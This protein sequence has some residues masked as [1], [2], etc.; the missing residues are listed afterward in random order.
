MKEFKKYDQNYTIFLLRANVL[1]DDNFDR[2]KLDIFPRT[3][4]G[5]IDYALHRKSIV[6][7]IESEI[8]RRFEKFKTDNP[9]YNIYKR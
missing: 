6:R 9:N 3:V 4:K 7:N 1:N 5:Y 8:K 2:F